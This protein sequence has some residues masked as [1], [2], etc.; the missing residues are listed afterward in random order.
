MGI[1]EALEAFNLKCDYLGSE[2]GPA[3]NRIKLR[4]A[5][6]VRAKAIIAAAGDLQ[7][8][9]GFSAKPLIAIA[10]G[11]ISVDIPRTDRQFCMLKDYIQTDAKHQTD[12]WIPIGVGINGQLLYANLCDPDT[13]HFLIAGTSGSGKTEWLRSLLVSLILGHSPTELQ[14]ALVDPKRSGF[15]EFVHCPW[16]YCPI[17]KDIESAL[18][19][20]SNLV[21]E[22]ESR[23]L[24]FE[25]AGVLDIQSYNATASKPLPLIVCVFDEFAD[26]ILQQKDEMEASV[27]RLGQMAR[28][29]GIH[30]ILGT[31][32]P[33]QSVCTPLI[34][35]NLSGRIALRTL[36]ASDSRIAIEDES[37]ASLLGKG[38]LL[39]K[40]VGNVE[41]LQGLYVS[42]QEIK[43]FLSDYTVP[44]PQAANVQPDSPKN[45]LLNQELNW[46][47]KLQG[48][49][50][51]EINNLIEQRR[52]KKIPLAHERLQKLSPEAKKILAYCQRKIAEAPE[53]KPEFISV[54]DIQA[55]RP[56][57]D[58]KA[59]DIRTW[60]SEIHAV[61]LAEY[62]AEKGLKPL[63]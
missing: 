30:L 31:Q 59:D 44:T 27:K 46:Q 25:A 24:L 20:L 43:A 26:F 11:H 63:G 15:T 10:P 6:G 2:T 35:A 39:Y 17:C 58:A 41:R 61:E 29:A 21:G 33:E 1:V 22:M 28:G 32:R 52:T 62:D 50:E 49:T 19:L 45:D 9:L 8:Q 16:L 38:D 42:S 23:Y 51:E 37:A 53:P 3:F 54:K 18:E 55:G 7:V 47:Q 12:L 14:I 13:C 57:K 40:A 60:L 34:K 48:M 4:P 36:Q 5:K 56:V